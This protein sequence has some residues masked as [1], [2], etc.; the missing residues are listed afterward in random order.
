[1]PKLLIIDGNSIINRAFYGIRPLTTRE[2]INTNGIY[3]FINIM[4]K[5]VSDIDPE[6]LT[7]AFDISR[8]TFRNEMFEEYKANRSGMPDELAQQM[9]FL[10]DILAA[11]NIPSLSLENYEADD[12]IGTVSLECEKEGIDCFILTGDRDDLQLASKKTKI[13]LVTT[14]GGKT[15][16]DIYDDNAVLSKYGLTPYEF[17]HLKG[18]MGD[19]SDNI[20]GV[21]GI[22]QVTATGL[23]KKFS[24]L[25]KLY[26][27]IDSPEITKGV[28]E[29]LTAD[30]EMAF[31]S[32]KLAT[33]IRN[34]PLGI[35]FNAMKRSDPDKDALK[36]IFDKL[37]FNA[38][39]KKYGLEE[40]GGVRVKADVS[41][42]P[43]DISINDNKF[44]YLFSGEY[45]YVKS[46]KTV[47]LKTE[48]N[49]P[50]LKEIFEN[51]DILKYSY[52]IKDDIVSLNG[53]GIKYESP[54]FDIKTAAYV[55]DPSAGNYRIETVAY[56]AIKLSS[57]DIAEV[58]FCLP[59]ICIALND[60]LTDRGAD[61]LFYDI[62]MPMIPILAAMQIRGI[63]VD[64][65]S[66]AKAG[67][68]FG[69]QIDSLTVRIYM[70][71]GEEFNINSPK[72][73][74]VVL[75]EKLGLRSGK[76]TK[77]GYSTGIEVLE[78]LRGEH[79]IIDALID[80]R[81][82]SKLKSTYV[83][84]MMNYIHEDSTIHSN[85]HQTVTQ[86]GRLSSSD[87]NL[88]NIPIR[89]ELGR[90]L[91]K[92]FVPV[93]EGNVFVSADYS[94]IELRVL[95]EICGD[96]N[97]VNA[98][99]NGEDIH[100]MAAAGI[101]G[102]PV[103]LVTEKMRSD[104]KKV[105]F[106]IIYGKTE[107]SLAKDLGVS[108]KEAKE[109]I[110]SYLGKYPNIRGYMTNIVE[111]AKRDG[112]VKTLYGRIRYIRELSD[113]NFNIRQAGER[114]ALN[115]PI[116]GTAADIIKI[117]MIKVSERLEREL[118]EAKLVLQIHDE[119]VIEVPERSSEKA[120]SILKDCMENAVKL[121]V[122]L[123]APVSCDRTL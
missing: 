56:T 61:K 119:L 42:N 64:K 57:D 66:L 54:R 69:K 89:N 26:E 102:V 122:P 85:F 97:L 55:C 17:I 101:Y 91:R 9:P 90:E 36:K 5:A 65:G 62:E 92:V 93:G 121:S 49:L 114:M 107:F 30:R 32:L 78:S 50:L 51:K 18:L 113:R 21:K 15:S 52:G 118:P 24:T 27:N 123:Y 34:A 96:E 44:F 88:Q 43:E 38:F 63:R 75:F 25:D 104:A 117:A 10:K 108:R 87:P 109:I 40:A 71:A 81:A 28:R 2:G 31:L 95:A 83:D 14:A 4:E 8:K 37:E 76:K 94:Q 68:D 1:M 84:G 106:G 105:D 35:D 80:Y 3:G 103:D 72:Q 12:I 73:L 6:Y 7:V 23:L 19:S 99:K 67:E 82:V 74:G 39:I 33:I 41:E 16:T 100:T 86:T 45:I 120:G 60:M 110:D 29:K 13:M 46:E 53:L 111:S 59:E 112:Y 20:P 115:T 11:M 22:G 98:F 58:V 48:E 77:T 70:L 116:Q 79:P 47:K